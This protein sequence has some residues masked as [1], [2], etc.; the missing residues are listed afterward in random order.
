MEMNEKNRVFSK[1]KIA[2]LELRNRIIRAGCFEGMC[3]NESPSE[4]LVEHH[5]AVAA[6]VSG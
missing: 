3:Q 1:A 2:D 5:R 6:G 4:A